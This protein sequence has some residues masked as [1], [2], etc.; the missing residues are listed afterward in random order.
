MAEQNKVGWGDE[1][2]ARCRSGSL[3]LIAFLLASVDSLAVSL[4]L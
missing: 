3:E 1:V 2:P 4:P